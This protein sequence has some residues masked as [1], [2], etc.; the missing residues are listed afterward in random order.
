M[1]IISQFIHRPTNLNP[2][3]YT[4]FPFN[5]NNRWFILHRKA[6]A[7]LVGSPTVVVRSLGR[8]WVYWRDCPHFSAKRFKGMSRSAWNRFY[9]K[10]EIPF[11]ERMRIYK[12]LVRKFK[13][14]NKPNF[15]QVVLSRKVRHS[16]TNVRGN[17][18]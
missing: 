17:Y 11:E 8:E 16:Q 3:G 14:E 10:Q 18:I 6:P 1:K 4:E 5:P 15:L 13:E 7:D 9:D 2:D 12:K